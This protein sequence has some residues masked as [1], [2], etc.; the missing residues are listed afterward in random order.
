MNYKGRLA[1]AGRPFP[2]AR[3]L[4]LCIVIQHVRISQSDEKCSED[5]CFPPFL[6]LTVAFYPAMILLLFF[7]LNSLNFMYK[8]STVG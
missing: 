7:G 5:I 6:Y 8:V 4:G 2:F 3:W 1:K